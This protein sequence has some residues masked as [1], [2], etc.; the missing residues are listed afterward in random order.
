MGEMRKGLF[1]D[2]IQD[3]N[4][5]AEIGKLMEE[6]G[7]GRGQALRICEEEIPLETYFQRRVKEGIKSRYPEAYIVKI[8][9]GAYSTGGIPDLMCIVGG[10]YFGFEIKRPIVNEPTEL[11]K[12][13]IRDIRKAG[14]TAEV[15]FWP[16]QAIEIIEKWRV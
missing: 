9:Q 16:E 6:R 7:V 1:K 5:D 3:F 13:V 8:A 4:P 15:V 11:Q 14:G 10:H 12:K 2:Y